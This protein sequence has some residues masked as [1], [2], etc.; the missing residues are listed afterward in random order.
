MLVIHIQVAPVQMHISPQQYHS[1]DR[2]T[3]LCQVLWSADIKKTPNQIML[4]LPCWGEIPLELCL[5]YSGPQASALW[6]KSF[7]YQN[8]DS[9]MSGKTQGHSIHPHAAQSI[10][11]TCSALPMQTVLLPACM[12]SHVAQENRENMDGVFL[13]QGLLLGH[14]QGGDYITWVYCSRSMAASAYFLR[15]TSFPTRKSG[16]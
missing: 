5:P 3:P 15:S 1:Q 8:R 10:T 14:R 9:F 13:W 6:D 12:E 16:V 11:W 4:F 2:K 7:S